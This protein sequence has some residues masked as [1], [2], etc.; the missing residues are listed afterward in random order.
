MTP[1]SRGPA[2]VLLVALALAAALAGCGPRAKKPPAERVALSIY[3]PCVISGPLRK[4][5][6]AYETVHPE[7]EVWT[8]TDKPL[9][10]PDR[11]KS[12]HERPSVVITMGEIEMQSLVKAGVVSADDVST[13]AVNTYALAVIA[14]NDG[15][16]RLRKL[17]DLADP[18]VKRIHLEDPTRSALG[19]RAK[20]AFQK[21]GLWDKI[22]GKIVQLDPKANV[23][24]QLLEGEADAAVVFK[25]CLFAEGAAAPKKINIVGELPADHRS[26]VYQAAAISTAPRPE[27]ARQFVD[28]LR[29]LE[30]RE[31]LERVGLTPSPRRR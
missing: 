12:D 13:I 16:L 26:I 15:K 19:D 27:V 21:L 9:A 24:D 3:V 7:V 17:P 30:G 5:I 25:D 11:V 10:L 6:G 2:G 4:V 8:E 23:V 1:R 18:R 28:F 31:S 20:R 14:P 29:S 22:A